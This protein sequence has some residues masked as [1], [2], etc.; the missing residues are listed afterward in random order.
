VDAERDVRVLAKQPHRI[1]RRGAR[2][3]QAAGAGDS[4]LDRLHH[5]SVDRVVHAEVVTVDD[6]HA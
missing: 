3:D 6:Q 4:V 1:R 5:G 2:D